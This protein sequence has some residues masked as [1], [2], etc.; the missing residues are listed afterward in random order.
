VASYPAVQLFL[1]RAAIARPGF[2][3]SVDSARAVAEICRRLDGLPLAIEL[4]AAR[5]RVLSPGELLGRLGRRLA[6]EGGARDLPERQRTLRATI[7]WSHQLLDGDEGRLFAYLSIFADGWTGQAAERIC[8]E[9]LGVQV[10]DGLES[11]MDHS[12]VQRVVSGRD[13]LRFDILAQARQNFG[14]ALRPS[15]DTWTEDM[16]WRTSTS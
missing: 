13:E 4:A 8:D 1:D 5:I 3:L 12:L 14:E 16:A 2:A 11:L 15:G 10:L 6:L 7:D 9:G